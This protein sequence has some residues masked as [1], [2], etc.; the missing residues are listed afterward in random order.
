[1]KC[2]ANEEFWDQF[3]SMTWCRMQQTQANLKNISSFCKV[4][5]AAEQA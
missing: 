4:A 1:M 5:P 3:N 2:L